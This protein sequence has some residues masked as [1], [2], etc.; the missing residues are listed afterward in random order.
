MAG[1]RQPNF[2]LAAAMRAAGFSN[3]SLARAVTQASQRLRK[4]VNTDHTRIRDWLA[5][6]QPRPDA[7]AALLLAFELRAERAY[8]A[9]EL[10][11]RDDSAMAPNLGLVYEKRLNDAVSVLTDLTRQD[12]NEHPEIR[13]ARYSLTSLQALCLDWLLGRTSTSSPATQLP[14]C[15]P[16]TSR[17]YGRC[18]RTPTCSTA[19]SAVSSTE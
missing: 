9:E 8:T 7:V 12:L 16:F 1:E 15:C 19:G 2:K 5:G 4:S 10:G 18:A 3:K 17:S 14:P 13:S 11:L 6:R